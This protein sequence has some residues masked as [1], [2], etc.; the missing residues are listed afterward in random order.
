MGGFSKHDPIRLLAH[1]LDF[2]L[3]PATDVMQD[4]LETF[5]AV[6][7]GISEAPVKLQ[8][9][10]ILD[11]AV[12][13]SPRVGSDLWR[14]A[15]DAAD[16]LSSTVE[17]ADADGRLRGILDAVRSNRIEDD[18]SDRWSF[19]KEDFERK[20]HRKRSNMKVTFVELTDTIA[21]QGPETEVIG[22]TVTADFLSLL[23]ERQRQIVVLLNSGYTNLTDVAEHLG[24]A[25][26][27]P[28]SKRLA[29]IRAQAAKF[30]DEC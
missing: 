6:D 2:W 14:G 15:E 10:S 11:G 1:N 18:F 12:R 22:N 3:P 26:H 13:A 8:D 25:N 16:A 9:G 17:A 20:L 30:F 19:A 5:P 4:I 21:V 28:I 29:K 27:S 23:D 24:Y 7:N